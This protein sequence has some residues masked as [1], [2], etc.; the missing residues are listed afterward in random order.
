MRR[1]RTWLIIAVALAVPAPSAAG[2]EFLLTD[3][4]GDANFTHETLGDTRPA[5]Y[6]HGDLLTVSVET[7]YIARPVGADGIDYEA[8][9][10]RV[11]TRTAAPADG[12][13]IPIAIRFGFDVDGCS[14]RFDTYRHGAVETYPP[15]GSVEWWQEGAGGDCPSTGQQTWAQRVTGWAVTTEG[16]ETIVTAPYASMSATERAHFGVGSTIGAASASTTVAFG[17]DAGHRWWFPWID[18]ALDSGNVFVI[19]SD[20]PPDVPCTRECG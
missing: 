3:I 20:V 5:S 6:E 4:A 15:D 2:T 7:T 18:F 16:N 13:T 19:G 1:F 10:L 12:T 8:T 14:H 17:T 11:R 9:G